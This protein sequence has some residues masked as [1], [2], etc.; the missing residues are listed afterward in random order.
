HLFFHWTAPVMMLIFP[1]MLRAQE[2]RFPWP[3]GKKMALSLSFDDARASNPVYG[4]PLLN[5]YGIKATFFVLPPQVKNNL[6]GWKAA[7]AS[8]HEMANHSYQ[9]PCSGN[10]VWSRTK[11]LENFTMDKMREELL[12]ANREIKDLLG[13]EPRV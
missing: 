5:E 3:D 8:G 6:E 9:H 1:G 13:V 10:F 7:V 12:R 2:A 4:V 11:A